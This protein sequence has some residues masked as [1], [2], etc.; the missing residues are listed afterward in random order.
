MKIRR[1]I[2]RGRWSWRVLPGFG[3]LWNQIGSGNRMTWTCWDL[4][5]IFY[6]FSQRDSSFV[7]STAVCSATF[8]RL[9]Q[10]L[11]LYHIISAATALQAA[12][13]SRLRVYFLC[14][15]WSASNIHRST[16]LSTFSPRLLLLASSAIPLLTLLCWLHQCC[17]LYIIPGMIKWKNIS[18][19]IEDFV[20]LHLCKLGGILRSLILRVL[21]DLIQNVSP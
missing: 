5:S 11:L 8:L 18:C 12:A 6:D 4:R 20:D 17:L 3:N 2:L 14:P 1:K 9:D 7:R 15:A 19:E 10:V 13:S 21:C 16:W